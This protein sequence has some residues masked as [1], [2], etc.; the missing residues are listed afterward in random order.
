M[1]TFA[2]TTSI[3]SEG[4]GTCLSISSMKTLEGTL[5]H[6]LAKSQCQIGILDGRIDI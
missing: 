3:F 4:L 5:V 2:L 6:C 1:H